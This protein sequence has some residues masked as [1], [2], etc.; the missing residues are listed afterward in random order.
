MKD[1]IL[2]LFCFCLFTVSLAAHVP[3]VKAG[4][5]RQ[6]A[7]E[8]FVV[9][10]DGKIVGKYSDLSKAFSSITDGQKAV[11][12][13]ES[14]VDLSEGQVK[15]SPGGA[16]CEVTLDLNGYSIAGGSST[17]LLVNE[18]QSF[19][20]KIS[21]PGTLFNYGIGSVLSDGTNSTLL[22]TGAVMLHGGQG[23][24]VINLPKGFVTIGS[25]AEL[26]S[27][28]DNANND[29]AGVVRASLVTVDGGTVANCGDGDIISSTADGEVMVKG[30]RILGKGKI[31]SSTIYCPSD[32]V[33]HLKSPAW[34]AINT[35]VAGYDCRV[36]V[37]D[38]ITVNAGQLY[39]KS[40]QT[41]TLTLIPD[42][43]AQSGQTV[44][45]RAADDG[46]PE[47]TELP[48]SEGSVPGTKR[49]SFEMP[50]VSVVISHEAA[51]D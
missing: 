35:D 28:N 44:Q 39:G 37:D 24:S 8:K 38:N 48:V 32:T 15:L 13:L 22:I 41:I 50:D 20:F 6:T 34:Y 26:I 36:Q 4:A 43:D 29:R 40:G 49:Y 47:L 31:T 17:A 27:C 1:K 23:N 14:S 25:G 10:I 30:G 51:A 7:N 3:D 9:L 33:G 46:N 18:S 16:N 21:G 19:D 11:V 45:V 2:T 42:G 5:V 12:R